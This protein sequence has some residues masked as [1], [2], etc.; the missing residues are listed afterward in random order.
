MKR[1]LIRLITT[2]VIIAI[3]LLIVFSENGMQIAEFIS[4]NTLLMYI[5]L[6]V[7]VIGIPYSLKYLGKRKKEKYIKKVDTTNV[8]ED[9]EVLYNTLY[10]QCLEELEILRKKVRIRQVIQYILYIAL[11]VGY[12]FSKTKSV[13]IDSQIDD[14]IAIL[15]MLLGFS[16]IALTYFNVKYTKKYKEEYKQ[17]V[18]SSFV[19]LVDNKLELAEQI[20]MSLAKDEYKM[21]NFDTKTYNT[22]LVSDQIDG[23]IEQSSIKV[24]DLNIKKVTG[25]T[26]HKE[27]QEIFQGLFATVKCN[28]NLEGVVKI[29]KNKQGVSTNKINLDSE[30]FEEY[31]DVYSTNKILTLRILTHDIMEMLVTF[32]N[33]YNLDFEI[34]FNNNKI[35]LRFSTVDMFEPKVF[36]SSIHKDLLYTEYVILKFILELT[37]KVNEVQL[38]IQ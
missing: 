17:K 32:H 25:S 34:V 26:K 28:N 9:F 13:I 8:T 12:M 2:F 36:G 10:T 35:Y 18:I 4:K 14:I 11:I 31:F 24:W 19:K 16:G 7:L 22:F 30:I 6:I 20:D 5:L 21:A 1:L 38:N 23:Y 3:M 29:S 33:K 15:G 37:K 27:T